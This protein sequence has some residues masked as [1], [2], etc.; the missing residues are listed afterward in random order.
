[1]QQLT[2]NAFI[3]GVYARVIVGIYN[4]VVEYRILN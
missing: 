1:M 2:I 3:F 4:M